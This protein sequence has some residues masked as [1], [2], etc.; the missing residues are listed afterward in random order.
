MAVIIFPY[1]Y[2]LTNK[3][4]KRNA[5][6]NILVPVDFSKDSINALNHAV[7]LANKVKANITIIHVRKD[8][9][10]DEPFIIKGKEQEY[11]KTVDEFLKELVADVKKNYTAG[12][13]VSYTIKVG[14]IYKAITDRAQEDRSYLIVMG[15]HGVSG[16]EELWMGS[17][18]FRVVSAA[19]CP[20]ITV[21]GGF[22]KFE[23]D[24]I[25]L[26]IDAPRESRKK[27]PFTTELAKALGAEVHVI[28]VRTTK[29]KDIVARLKR[30]VDQ[31]AEYIEKRGIKVVTSERF[32][33]NIADLT[34][35]YA[36]DKSARLI[37]VMSDQRG[38]PVTMGISSN[39]QQMVNHS[40]IPVLSIHPSYSK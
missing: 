31:T 25:V 17:N 10:Y 20:V 12:G 28:S 36:V 37:A 29:R 39:S 24:R 22:R 4:S 1:F 40:P 18:A 8:K 5:M 13:S 19:P 9:N 2:K 7:H 3:S 32:G 14:K 11:G 34:Y 16:F 21:R 23:L 6:K 15:T 33:S 35:S 38:K 30:Y 27:V 26:P